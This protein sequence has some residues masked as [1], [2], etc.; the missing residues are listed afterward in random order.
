[1][2]LGVGA[3]VRVLQ[4]RQRCSILTALPRQIV[5][6]YCDPGVEMT[7]RKSALFV[8]L[9]LLTFS[10]SVV[11]SDDTPV[12]P[13]DEVFDRY[14]DTLELVAD[15]YS[16][17][18]S[19]Y[20]NCVQFGFDAIRL[21]AALEAGERGVDNGMDVADS[22][23]YIEHMAQEAQRLIGTGS[24]VG[25]CSWDD[26]SPGSP[27]ALHGALGL[28]MILHSHY[29]ELSQSVRDE[30][31]SALMAN[32][33]EQINPY[34]VN[35]N[36]SIVAGKLLGGE[37]V[38]YDSELWEEGFELLEE[39][40]IQTRTSGGIEMNSPTYTHYHFAA[41]A[42]LVEMLDD[43]EAQQMAQILTEYAL[44]VQA[45]LYLPGGG[46]GAPRS[47]DRNSGADDGFVSGLTRMLWLISGD[48][49]WEPSS[50]VHQGPVA[51]AEYA[52]PHA[53]RS[54]F[55]DKGDGYR[56]GGYSDA[57]TEGASFRMPYQAY[58]FSDEDYAIGD[59]APWH[60]VV[61]PDAMFGINYGTRSHRIHVGMG[62]YGRGDGEFPILYHHHPFVDG[63]TMDGGGNPPGSNDDDPTNFHQEGYDH[64][65]M[66]HHR[67]MVSLW[68]PTLQL[69]DSGVVRTHKDTRVHLPNWEH[70]G[71]EMVT[72]DGWYVGQMGDAYI[73]YRP[74]GEITTEESRDG[75]S[76]TYIILDERSGAIVELAT[77][78][79]FD[80]VDDYLDD[81]S[82][83]HVEFSA[84]SGEDDFY[85][86]F[87]AYNPDTGGTE[88]MRLEY[89]PEQR[90]VEGDEIPL[91]E[92]DF[93][94]VDSLFASWDQD[95]HVLELKRGCYESVIYD[96]DAR[97]ID[98][99]EPLPENCEEDPEDTIFSDVEYYGDFANWEPLNDERW[100]IIEDDDDERRLVL[101]DWDFERE[102]DRLG[103]YALVRDRS[104]EDFQLT[105]DART[106]ED[107]DE[108]PNADYAVIFGW[109]NPDD[110]YFFMANSNPEHSELF[111]LEDGERTQLGQ[112]DGQLIEDEDW[113]EF[114]LIREGE[115]VEVIV[116]GQTVLEA[117]LDGTYGEG[118]L[119][120]G[121]FNDSAMF[122]NVAVTVPGE[123]DDDE[124]ENGEG[125]DDDDEG[126]GEG[127]DD[128][129]EEE[130][131]CMA[132]SQ[133]SGGST[134]LVILA[135]VVG[136]VAWRRVRQSWSPASSLVV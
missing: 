125:D 26:P 93:G 105:M 84:G 36:L 20:S 62:V 65:R 49:A 81:L 42:P 109:E 71:G 59:V 41:L 79:D 127:D 86:E 88:Q 43:D 92:L 1:M 135:L 132:C 107:L 111:V 45:H 126:D 118:R 40:F 9:V 4:P 101:H 13:D 54:V 136:L 48:D 10:T 17:S 35:G 98:Y 11:A 74:L 22:E 7:P 44:L 28:G 29:D 12:A 57:P 128:T 119:G 52:I 60:A 85:A 130:P 76:W 50:N 19:N 117:E 47:R 21:A 91:E 96:W 34:L 80:S 95:D 89:R 56:F 55:L 37:A 83:R 122:D 87:D 67:A 23:E 115:Q 58:P 75:D 51:I 102:G 114:E 24:T 106:N 8:L 124:G 53:L 14:D 108:E 99:D 82:E 25:E 27:A 129:A 63:D 66:V 70:Y 39:I 73:A 46:V 110:Y 77:T 33:R 6:L 131:G 69:K 5:C 90:F 134:P 94:L 16:E 78:D 68:D 31:E 72:G 61:L 32:W 121:S 30:L 3:T 103:E 64:E 112:V 120:I 100:S 116:A 38:G 97:I 113:H 2:R 123:E 133:A 104:Y 18:L 15:S